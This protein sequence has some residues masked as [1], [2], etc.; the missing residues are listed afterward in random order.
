MSLNITGISPTA[1]VLEQDQDQVDQIPA[2]ILDLQS[3]PV[4]EATTD[5]LPVA[6][7]EVS[8]SEVTQIA[9]D[10]AER[11]IISLQA[12]DVA[13]FA[14][15]VR[16]AVIQLT[17]NQVSE[18]ATDQLPVA[19]LTLSAQ[20]LSDSRVESDLIDPAE[21]VYTAQSAVEVSSDAIQPVSIEI[22]G[23]ELSDKV[24]DRLLT[25][26]IE[27]VSVSVRDEL[28]DLLQAN[29]IDLSAQPLSDGV[30]RSIPV[31]VVEIEGIEV[32][33]QILITSV[34]DILP[35]TSGS[36]V[37]IKILN[38]GSLETKIYRAKGYRSAQYEEIAQISGD[39]YTDTDV[40]TD[41]PK[42]KATFTTGGL[43]GR[44]SLVRYAVDK[45][46]IM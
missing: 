10:S 25:G 18:L 6:S 7:I 1:G 31:A 45:E 15:E 16:P 38:S 5:S 42:Y 11:S 36:D 19:S 29:Q 4:S 22:E 13:D 3:R 14:G 40:I 21:I 20:Q 32:S 46:Q 41:N 34:P 23:V 35:T 43:E 8:A 44:H 26:E 30:T 28:V 24:V 2:S 9:S 27:V 12:Q 33:E 17:A 37:V 39:T